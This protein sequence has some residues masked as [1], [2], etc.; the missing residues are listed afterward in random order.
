MALVIMPQNMASS[1]M[2]YLYSLVLYSL[3]ADPFYVYTYV[4]FCNILYKYTHT[5]RPLI[6]M[7]LHMCPLPS[8]ERQKKKKVMYDFFLLTT[9]LIKITK[10]IILVFWLAKAS[11]FGCEPLL[12]KSK[13]LLK[14]IKLHYGSNYCN[15][16]FFYSNIWIISCLRRKSPFPNK[17]E[18]VTLN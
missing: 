9:T 10:Y 4:L 5:C 15:G 16:L 14:L 2:S 12:Y 17:V 6:Y 13:I 3:T 11:S 1:H 8:T 7:H 18:L